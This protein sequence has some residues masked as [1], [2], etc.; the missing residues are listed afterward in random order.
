M[1]DESTAPKYPILDEIEVPEPVIAN[2]QITVDL[3][4]EIAGVPAALIMRVHA[5]DIEVFVASRGPGN[6]YHPGEKAP[7]DTGLYCETVMSTQCKLL[8]PNALKDPHWDHNPDITL[9]MISYCGLPLTWPN[10]ELFGTIR[11]LDKKENAY[12]PRTHQLL[13]RFRDSIQFSLDSIYTAEMERTQRMQAQEAVKTA[14]TQVQLYLDL[15][16]VII[17]AIDADQRVTLINKKGAELLGYSQDEI[18]GMNWY[19]TFIPER[20][21]EQV[22][23]ASRQLMRGEIAPVEYFENPVVTR[24]GEE[25]L[26]AWHNTVLR[27]DEGCIIGTLSAGEDITER[28]HAENALQDTLTRL[29]TVLDTLPIGVLILDAAS[30]MVQS[31]GQAERIYSGAASLPE[32]LQ[33]YRRG[34]AWWTATGQVV[35]DDDWPSAQALHQGVVVNDQEIDI[36]RADGA[37]A[38][39]LE[40][41]APLRDAQEQITGAVVVVQDITE[42]KQMELARRESEERLRFALETSHIGAWDL[43]LVDHT[44]VRSLEHDRIFGYAELLPEW[45]Y[46]MFLDHVLPEDRTKV[47]QTFQQ[48]MA[49]QGEWNFECRIRRTDDAVRWI[50]AAGRHMLTETGAA[51]HMVG[52]VQDITERKHAEEALRESE[53]RYRELVQNANSAIIRW[54]VDGTITFFNEYAQQFFGYTAEEVIGQPV[55]ILVPAQASSGADWS[56]LVRDIAE[57]PESYANFA[58]ENVLRDGRQVWMT[59]TNKPIFDAQ[60]Q[61]VEILAIGSDITQQK[62]VEQELRQLNE[63]LDQRVRERTAQLEAANKEM[64]AFTYSV[65]HDL[66][67][68]LRAVDGFSKAILEDY[69]DKLDEEGKENLAF[70]RDG[71]QQMGKLIDDMLRL[72]RAGRTEMRM[73]RVSLSALVRDIADDL[74]RQDPARQVEWRIAPD[75][76]AMGD[77]PLLRI[78]LENLLSNAW[79]F[80]GRCPAARIEFFS[81]Q[82]G[83]TTVYAIRDNGAGFDMAYVNKLFAPF[84]RLHTAEEFPGTGIGLAIVQRIINRHGGRIWAEGAVNQGATFYFTLPEPKEA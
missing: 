16:G 22:T 27:D 12:P 82:Q 68:P 31:N 54:R 53:R 77:Q 67:A 80:T 74:Q 59:W 28:R 25:H 79:K 21:R 24:A 46:D 4:A 18:I 26:I 39:I 15:V 56:T 73:E 69:A 30:Q 65:S 14:Q 55:S 29:R 64:E 36:R 70:I 62:Q 60:G 42:R 47:N 1:P 43:D 66:R 10:G 83:G 51:R 75:V 50:W 2:W 20:L 48:A 84:Q 13:E 17:V 72:S 78:L 19:A 81:S 57:H 3:L 40:T 71:A 41:A 33:E 5:H 37:C 44:A 76:S 9:G 38:N 35:Q 8:V 32:P 11:T 61:L 45:T 34:R 23:A 63:T 6:V 7:L 58:N 52:I 49:T